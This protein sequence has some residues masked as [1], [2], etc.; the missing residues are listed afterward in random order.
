MHF[1]KSLILRMTIDSDAAATDGSSVER[2]A[3][4]MHAGTTGK[5]V[6][7]FEDHLIGDP[8]RLNVRNS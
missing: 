3:R 7:C 5:M 1:C 8:V 4:A 2:K 6:C